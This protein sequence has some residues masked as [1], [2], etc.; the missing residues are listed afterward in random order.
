MSYLN[1]W[2]DYAR[3]LGTAMNLFVVV[4]LVIRYK[5]HHKSWNEKT[6]DLW[7][8][9]LMWGLAGIVFCVQGIVLDRPFTPGFVF[10]MAATLVAGK[11]VHAKGR[12]GGS[13]A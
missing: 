11:G 5:Q 2:H 6:V 9:L 1:D 7:Y 10:L 3:V 12:W 8:S 4:V 13:D